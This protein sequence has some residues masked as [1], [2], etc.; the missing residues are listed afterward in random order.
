MF[1]DEVA[2]ILTSAGVATNATWIDPSTG[3][4]L[5]TEASEDSHLEAI[6]CSLL[7]ADPLGIDGVDVLVTVTDPEALTLLEEA[8]AT[9]VSRVEKREAQ[10]GHREERVDEELEVLLANV[11]ASA[12]GEPVADGSF[13][14]IGQNE[15][16]PCRSADNIE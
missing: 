1:G 9:S 7:E 12:G 5:K 11:S 6:D 8:G 16:C 3:F 14:D 2:S 15:T 13:C 10:G 4:T